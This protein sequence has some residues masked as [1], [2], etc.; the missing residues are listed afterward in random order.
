MIVAMLGPFVM[1]MFFLT[2][3]SQIAQVGLKWSPKAM[4]VNFNKFNPLPAI[5]KLFFSGNTVIELLKSLV[6]VIAIGFLS[7]RVLMNELT[8]SGRFV[9]LSASEIMLR[10]GEIALKVIIH[11]GI[12]ICII[13]V[14]DYMIARYRMEQK[15][16]MTKQE[17]KDEYKQQDGDPVQKGRMRGRQR[18]M[19]RQR[20]LDGVATADV[21]V[22]NPTH[23][24]AALRYKVGSDPAPV[25][26]ALGV[27][28][29]AAKIRERARQNGVPIVPS[30]KLA[31]ALY[32]NG[33]VG[34]F[35]PAELYQAVASILAWVYNIKGR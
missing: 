8:N 22:V 29:M 10:I 17:V 14:I 11:T 31:R 13:A 1:L 34:G 4:E 27:D 19:A 7:V 6:K 24:S 18:D 23:Y 16:K 26:V 35:I 28:E 12:A 2:I 33:K 32:S 9:A 15:M 30:P 5:P 25:I 3:I 21:V 20:M